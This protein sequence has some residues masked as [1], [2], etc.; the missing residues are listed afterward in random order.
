MHATKRTPKEHPSMSRTTKAIGLKNTQMDADSELFGMKQGK[1]R[2]L[3]PETVHDTPVMTLFAGPN[4]AGKSTL[5][6]LWSLSRPLGQIIDSDALARE[7]HLS[8][9][10]AG[11]EAI[12]RVQICIKIRVSFSLETTLSGNLI[13]SKLPSPERRT[14][15]SICFISRYLLHLLIKNE[16]SRES[17]WVVTLSRQ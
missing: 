8:D 14:S 13:F 9:V 4:G 16:W 10:A 7:L 1:G 3:L 15:E 12:R 2:S 5:R 11:R 17:L 6:E